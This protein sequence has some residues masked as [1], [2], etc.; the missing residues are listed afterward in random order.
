M[1]KRGTGMA[2]MANGITGVAKRTMRAIGRSARR[3]RLRTAVVVLVDAEN[4]SARY[5]SRATDVARMAG[6]V[7]EVR[8]YGSVA[9]MG[10]ETW[11]IAAAAFKAKRVPCCGCRM[12]KNSADIRLAI[13]AMDIMAR[14]AAQT[15]VIVSNDT[16]FAPLA[17]RL[18]SGGKRVIGVGDLNRSEQYRK[19][20]D[21]Y[22]A[23]SEPVAV[24]VGVEAASGP[25]AVADDL[26]QAALESGIDSATLAAAMKC[27]KLGAQPDSWCSMSTFGSLMRKER[28]SFSAKRYG[29]KNMTAFAMKTGLFDVRGV[30]PDTFI[31]IRAA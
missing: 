25:H 6:R 21:D 9:L 3:L 19:A 1:E 5:L 18:R 2:N 31:R 26:K 8:L 15:F 14:K 13:D 27:A 7:R 16:D 23:V 28:P 30:Q 24:T 20:F 10:S 17:R 22:V 29:C 11:S 4:V 12:G